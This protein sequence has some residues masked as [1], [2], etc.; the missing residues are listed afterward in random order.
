MSKGRY[1]FTTFLGS[2]Y[3]GYYK[4]DHIGHSDVLRAEIEWEFLLE[5]R[6]YGVRT[7]KAIVHKIT[8]EFEDRTKLVIDDGFEISEPVEINEGWSICD[9]SVCEDYVDI[10][11]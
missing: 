10:Q 2:K 7:A 1:P 4:D 11:F 5:V 6:D 8:V 3:I 9:I